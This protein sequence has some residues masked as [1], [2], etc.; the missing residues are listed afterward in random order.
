ME[1]LKQWR[2]KEAVLMNVIT[3]ALIVLFIFYFYHSV[4]IRFI[5]FTVIVLNGIQAICIWFDLSEKKWR[6]FSW[7]NDLRSYEK[8]KLGTEWVKQK[9]NQLT[10]MILSVCLYFLVF[11]L[12]SAL[13]NN[14]DLPFSY[15]FMIVFAVFL[16]FLNNIQL[17]LNSR[18]MDTRTSNI[19]QRDFR[20]DRITQNIVLMIMGSIIVIFG[21]MLF[22]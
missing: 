3:A 17:Y 16:F 1:Q 9:R 10:S 14:F 19:V 18:K 2:F 15:W 13:N 4:N 5:F 20:A 12:S 7:L 8:E 22:Q 6:P 11:V 21:V